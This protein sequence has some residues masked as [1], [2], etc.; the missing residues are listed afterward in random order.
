MGCPGDLIDGIVVGYISLGKEFP[1]RAPIHI[2]VVHT[3]QEK[4]EAEAVVVVGWAS[5]LPAD[6]TIS[7]LDGVRAFTKFM[8]LTSWRRTRIRAS[9]SLFLASCALF[10]TDP[11]VL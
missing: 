9:S 8:I 3:H 6:L 10:H 2:Y 7:S 1:N 4:K 5:E 11:A